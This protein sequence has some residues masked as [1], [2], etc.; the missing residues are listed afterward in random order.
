MRKFTRAVAPDFLIK[1]WEAWG[2]EYKRNRNKKPGFVFQWPTHQKEKINKILKP[3]L[4]AL[5]EK[6]CSFCDNF[7]LR[8]KEDSIDHFKPKS[9]EEYFDIVC[10]WENLY[11][12]C[13]NC[14]QFKKEQ[15]SEYLLRPDAANYS[16]EKYF[17]YS[18]DKHKIKPNPRSSAKE[19]KQ[20]Q[21]TID[22]FGLN[23]PGNVAG[24]RNYFDKYSNC[25]KLGE[26]IFINDFPFRF[27]FFQ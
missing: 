15:Y 10:Q 6:H 1:K 16:F 19:V 18:F 14:Q 17:I 5:T 20:A 13:H 7:P 23:D 22:V 25:V 26:A 4:A 21:T 24:R 12:C 11:Y 2:A 3:L 27:M 8:T 9:V